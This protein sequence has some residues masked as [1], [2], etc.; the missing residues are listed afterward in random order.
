MR[1]VLRARLAG[2]APS[3]SPSPSQSLIYLYV[4]PYNRLHHR[5]FRVSDG[6][7]YIHISPAG[8]E[9][10]AS[11]RPST[12]TP[13]QAAARAKLLRRELIRPNESNTPKI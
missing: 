6:A 4:H 12:N 9:A 1:Y 2:R 3:V 11:H 5:I 7:A 8:L 13:G 10:G